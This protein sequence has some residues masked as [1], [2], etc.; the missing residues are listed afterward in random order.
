MKIL[1]E[2]LKKIK[3]NIEKSIRIFSNS[4]R[5]LKTSK[6]KNDIKKHVIRAMKKA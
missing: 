5:R 3:K 2:Y 1:H 4:V 6:K